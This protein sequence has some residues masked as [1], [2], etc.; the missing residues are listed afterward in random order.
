[1]ATT[2]EIITYTTQLCL[3]W[4]TTFDD[5]VK[6]GSDPTTR[7]T[8]RFIR[9]SSFQ[10]QASFRTLDADLL[11]RDEYE[12][13]YDFCSQ[14]ISMPEDGQYQGLA[15]IGHPGIGQSPLHCL[16]P[17]DCLTV[18]SRQVAISVVCAPSSRVRRKA[19]RD[20][21]PAEHDLDFQQRPSPKVYSRVGSNWIRSP[22]G[23]LGI[24]RFECIHQGDL[25]TYG[26][27]RLCHNPSDVT[28][29]P[30]HPM[31]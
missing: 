4:G 3:S 2:Q 14:D 6:T 25:C 11:I 12:N 19:H 20:S 13:L 10:S 31:G 18:M 9:K 15:V 8:Y 21:I 16:S 17:E 29:R 28:R 22:E 30:L 27:Q 23:R 7:D 24:V 1:M 5:L 26:G